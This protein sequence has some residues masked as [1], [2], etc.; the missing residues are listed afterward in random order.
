MAPAAESGIALD[1]RLSEH[2]PSPGTGQHPPLDADAQGTRESLTIP[3]PVGGEG[4]SHRELRP[5]PE[6]LPSW[7]LPQASSKHLLEP[8][9]GQVGRALGVWWETVLFLS[10]RE[11]LATAGGFL[12]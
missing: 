12:T 11:G 9:V 3:S 8:P 4:T 5:P 2:L 10:P 7:V 6:T 1:L